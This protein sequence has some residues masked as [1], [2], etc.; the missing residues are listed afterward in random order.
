MGLEPETKLQM[1]AVRDIG[2]FARMAFDEPGVWLGRE[3]EIAGDSLT[4]PEVAAAFGRVL[5]RPVEYAA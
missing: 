2:V 4:M 5:G 3:V 1:I